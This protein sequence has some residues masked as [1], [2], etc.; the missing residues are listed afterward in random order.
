MYQILAD[1]RE[2][3]AQRWSSNANGRKK[4]YNGADRR[5]RI[6][7]RLSATATHVKLA[8]ALDIYILKKAFFVLEA[9]KK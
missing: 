1:T 9:I 8:C 3:L 7:H 2:V 5:C 6:S 4:F